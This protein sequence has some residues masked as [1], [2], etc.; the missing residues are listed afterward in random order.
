MKSDRKAR[1]RWGLPTQ[2]SVGAWIG[3]LLVAFLAPLLGGCPGERPEARIQAGDLVPPIEIQRLDGKKLDSGGWKGRTVVLNLWATWCTPCRDEMPA[4]ERLANALDPERF[5]V[6]GIA[7]DEDRNLVREFALQTGVTFP[8]GVDPQGRWVKRALG[9]WA[10]PDTLI[11]APDGRLAARVLGSAPWDSAE[12]RRRVL[13]VGQGH[14][15]GHTNRAAI[16]Q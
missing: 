9:S 6:V 15:D 11:I 2:T 13:A 3:L 1:G 7:L 16:A 12:M 14:G 5:Q 10:L 4:L 8:L